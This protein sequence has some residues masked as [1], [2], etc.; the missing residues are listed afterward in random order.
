M[1]DAIAADRAVL[2]D[3]MFLSARGGY[4][5]ETTRCAILRH[6]PPE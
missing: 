6:Q 4:A 1:D 5:E 3:A 2:K